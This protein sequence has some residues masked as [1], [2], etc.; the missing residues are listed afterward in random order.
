MR[1]AAP[2]GARS[3]LREWR[4]FVW[5]GI[6]LLFYQPKALSD[7]RCADTHCA[8]HKRKILRRLLVR[9]H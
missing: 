1:A 4:K 5:E 8:A 7:A 3:A 2:S 6:A 9:S